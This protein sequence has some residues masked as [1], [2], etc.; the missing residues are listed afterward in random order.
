[1]NRKSAKTCYGNHYRNSTPVGY[2]L[3]E[4][5]VDRWLR[6]HSLEG[7]KRYADNDVEKKELLYRHLKTAQH[8]LGSDSLTLFVSCYSEK[9]DKLDVLYDN[10]YWIKNF[11]FS[12]FQTIDISEDDEDPYYMFSF[13]AEFSWDC[14][15]FEEIVSD[16]ADEN[17][18]SRVAFFSEKTKGIYAPYDGGADLFFIDKSKKKEAKSLLSNWLS[19][20]ESGL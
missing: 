6:I 11:D 1:M 2:M 16:V 14:G 10:P 7:G 3:R 19:E 9:S 13:V 5:H 8:V 20:H 18:S 15:I 4:K 12:L 17:V